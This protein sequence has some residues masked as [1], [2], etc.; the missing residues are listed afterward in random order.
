MHATKV[1]KM[2]LTEISATSV[3]T[4]V[5]HTAEVL[6]KHVPGS[7]VGPKLR[8]D[9]RGI[10]HP[11]SSSGAFLPYQHPELA[12]PNVDDFALAYCNSRHIVQCDS[13]N[14]LRQMVGDDSVLSCLRA[15]GMAS[16]A[17][18]EHS[19]QAVT[20]ARAYYV[21]S[22]QALNAALRSTSQM[23]KNSTLMT[24]IALSYFESIL[25]H[26]Q[27]GMKAWGRH[28]EGTAALLHIRG[29]EQM[30]TQ[31]GLVLFMQATV[32]IMS[33]CARFGRRLPEHVREILR[34]GSKYVVDSTDPLW[35]VHV[36]WG[37][38]VDFWSEVLNNRLSDANIII[39][40]ASRMDEQFMTAYDCATPA[41]DY[42]VRYETSKNNTIPYPGYFHLYRNTLSAQSWNT[43]RNGRLMLSTI[44]IN[45]LETL[46]AG[47][48]SV[49]DANNLLASSKAVARQMSNE[50]L[51][52]VPQYMGF[53]GLED[54]GIGSFPTFGTGVSKL[55]DYG[56][57]HLPVL[58]TSN[59]YA[60]IWCL[61]SVGQRAPF[62]S[63][64]RVAACEALRLSSRTLGA[65][66]AS[67]L[68]EWL[69]AL[70]VLK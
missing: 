5:A 8:S 4:D 15:L 46:E 19:P 45:T 49:E 66:Q 12:V 31:E 24:A 28:I 69:E 7:A 35:R 42:E 34:D 61:A 23:N 39:A 57:S 11:C 2:Q 59:G 44:I 48:R 63:T 27:T 29:T 21:S 33:N 26:D 13:G 37:E 20:A 58:R 50:I 55:M 10:S 60:L 22:I 6:R 14:S 16:F 56:Q 1:S 40:T 70:P 67:Y 54:C 3:K 68:A 41:W 53:P 62:G 36:T 30:R 43:M 51:A 17:V 38:L 64:V 52:S 65:K 9:L 25:G 32:N 47:T 18:Y